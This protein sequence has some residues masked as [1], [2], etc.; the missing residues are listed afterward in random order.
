MNVAQEDLNSFLAVA[1]ELKVKGLTQSHMEPTTPPPPPHKQARSRDDK[2]SLQ[3]PPAKRG[4]PPN[5]AVNKQPP[6]VVYEPPPVPAEVLPSPNNVKSEPVG[7]GE[8]HAITPAA[9]EPY[10]NVSA[11]PE[12]LVEY[13]DD[14]GADYESGGGYEAEG[15]YDESMM[16][17]SMGTP[18]ADGNK[19]RG[20]LF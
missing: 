3:P 7:S 18:S 19:G 16:D 20:A 9:V 2:E 1:E 14:Y 11:A 4:R 10:V 6:K 15:S 13:G 12:A 8:A 17:N 5:S